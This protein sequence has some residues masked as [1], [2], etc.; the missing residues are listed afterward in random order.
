VPRLV[1]AGIALSPHQNADD[2]SATA[3]RERMLWL[4]FEALPDDPDDAYFV[5]VLA[6]AADPLL[7]REGIAEVVEPILALDSEWMRMVV[8]GQARDDNGLRAMQRL[9]RPSRPSENSGNGAHFLVPLPDGLGAGSSE[10]LS[11]FTYEIRLGHA[12]PRW[13][14]AQG[15]FG[16]ALRVAGVQHPPPPLVCQAVRTANEIRLRAPF[17]TPVQDGRHV[18]PPEGPKTRLWGLLY[19]RVQQADGAAWRNLVL[20]RA[21]LRPPQGDLAER[22][23]ETS[24][25]LI[26][27]E[28]QFALAELHSLLDRHGLDLDAPLTTLVVEFHTDPEIEDPL[29]TQLGHARMLRVSPLI[30]V[31]EAC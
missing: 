23:P 10:L 14:T 31:P 17:A 7:T 1:S 13:S 12:G 18:R 5:R 19:A 4:E 20:M 8:P 21:P 2:Y 30:S 16:P 11:L 3:Q 26:Y 9:Q 6:C 29:G 27:G 24:G 15:R 28:G 22:H 25:P